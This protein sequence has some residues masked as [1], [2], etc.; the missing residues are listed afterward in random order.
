LDRLTWHQI[1]RSAFGNDTLGETAI[2]SLERPGWSAR[3]F[4]ALPEEIACLL[5]DKAN[6]AAAQS[7][8]KFR[9][10]VGKLAF[11]SSEKEPQELVSE[12]V[13]W[14]ELIH[15]VYFKTVIFRK[16]VCYAIAHSP[17][18]APSERLKKSPEYEKLGHWIE[19]IEAPIV[20]SSKLKMND[21]P[22]S[23]SR[24]TSS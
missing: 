2:G 21:Q 23:L 3:S 19:E 8:A 12:Y 1:R 6:E 18:F 20:T 16:L 11:S 24:A 15:N 22:H 7:I 17:G 14:N 13:S 5:A 10:A 4:S 9:D